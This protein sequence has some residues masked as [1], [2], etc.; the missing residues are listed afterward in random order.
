MMNFEF[1][2]SV[3]GAGSLYKECRDA[4]KLASAMPSLSS[5]CARKAL[6]IIVKLL[7]TAGVGTPQPNASLFEL[8]SDRAFEDFIKDDTVLTAIHTVRKI[9]NR[10]AHTSSVSP[11]EACGALEQLQYIIGES[12]LNCGAIDDYPPFTSPLKVPIQL[13]TPTISTAMAP[14]ADSANALPSSQDQSADELVSEFAPKLRNARFNVRKK[15]DE[16]ENKALFIRSTLRE[17]DWP[18]AKHPNQPVPSTACIN[19]TLDDG[20]TIDYILYG[21]DSKPLAIIDTTES[22]INPISGRNKVTRLASSMETKYGYRPIAYYAVGYHIFCIDQLGFPARRVFG[23]HTLDELDLLKQRQHSRKDISNPAIDDNITNRD[24]QKDGIRSVCNAFLSNRRRSLL[25]MATGTGKTRV[26]ISLSDILLKANWVKNILFLADRTSLVR[27]AHKNFNKLLPNVTTSIYAGDSQDRDPNA[28]IIFS[29]YQTMVKLVDGDSREFGIGRFDLII[30]DE[31]HRSIFKKYGSLFKYFDALL[32]GLTATPRCEENKST[33]EV[34]SLPSGE[35]DYAYE[36]EEAIQD[37]YLVGFSVLDRT[38]EGMRSGI[39]YDDL[40]DEQ[41]SEIEDAFSAVD[42]DIALDS[43]NGSVIT[44]ND[45]IINIGTIDAMLSDLMTNGLKINAGDELGKTIIF[46]K[47]HKEAEVIV[48]RFNKLYE[49]LGHDYCKLIDSKVDN[50]LS[51]IDRFGE[52]ESLPQIA[53]SVD[54]L[55]TGIDV[56]DILNLVFFKSMKSK[57][58]FLQMIGRGTRLSP[59][60]FGP[61]V[62]KRGF[63]VLDYFDNFRYFNTRETW[64]TK[65]GSG[66]SSQS[67]SQSVS[68]NR[69]RLSILKQLQEHGAASDYDKKYQD[70][71]RQYF[72][73][74]IRDLNNDAIEVAQ[75]M[76]FVS[77]FRTEEIWSS[78]N[79]ALEKEIQRHILP[80]LPSERCSAKV[81]SF[82]LLMLAIED[83]YLKRD[84]EGKDP[85]GIKYGFKNANDAVALRMK[86]LL[87][88]KTVPAVSK[89]EK[90]ISALLDDSYLMDDFSLEKAEFVRTELRDLMSLIPDKEEYYIINIPDTLIVDEEPTTVGKRKSYE[91]KVNEYLSD[92]SNVILAK[93]RMLEP[94]SKD[95]FNELRTAFTQTLGSPSDYA[96]WSNNADN[97]LPFIRKQVGIAQEAIDSS[98]ESFLNSGVLTEAQHGFLTQIIEYAR[99]NGDVSST[100][101]L[102]ES[103]FCDVDLMK[104][105]GQENFPYV[106]QLLDGLHKPI[107][108]P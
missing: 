99:A 95:E 92:D 58:K 107:M 36:L 101:L 106:K 93:I 72:I 41:K 14:D 48:E 62:D 17:A 27:Q 29:T 28:R 102:S 103:P 89:K 57:I 80:L 39:R 79:D 56:P 45:K 54:M 97:L 43:L 98:F 78:I 74:S 32:V 53:V 34:F 25:V 7:Y 71:L 86:D 3:P 94:L 88:L 84:A 82:D 108:E 105:F 2:K 31:A 37:G 13:E 60:I 46:A 68:I 91:E 59:D 69:R 6:E 24:Y 75:S 18:I 11:Q 40:T 23:F 22:S 38:T 10:A 16:A 87:E 26:S 35:P 66:I 8:V 52:R 30:I 51:L 65:R 1:L 9:G 83:E 47:N 44:P 96:K 4:E 70:D 64:S 5:T 42:S 19:M 61:G 104:L 100:T 81:K 12:L 49:H 85:R 20:S 63:L 76:A 21:R 90:L 67:T 50:S 77:K 55:D 73:V 33:Y 15:R